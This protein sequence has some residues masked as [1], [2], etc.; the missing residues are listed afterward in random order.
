MTLQTVMSRL[1]DE[2]S[3]SGGPIDVR[4]FVASCFPYDIEA[5]QLLERAFRARL[6]RGQFTSRLVKF[7]GHISAIADD[8]RP[9]WH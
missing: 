9:V 5:G 2:L 8:T 4:R 6:L 7:E 3:R 1:R